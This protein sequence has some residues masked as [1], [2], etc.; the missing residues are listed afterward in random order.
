MRLRLLTIPLLA[1][2]LLF[3]TLGC[4]KKDAPKTD[5]ASTGSYKLDGVLKTCEV[6]SAFFSASV[7]QSYDQLD[8]SL[9]T[10]P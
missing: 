2:T 7:S 4:S 3:S 5:S 10:I 1:S 9:T 8:I 6:K